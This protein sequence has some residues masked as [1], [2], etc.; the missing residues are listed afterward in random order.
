MFETIKVM[1]EYL[2]DFLYKIIE[3][4]GYRFDK[5]EGKIEKI[6]D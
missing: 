2:F 3:F 4:F 5:E 6:E 1:Y